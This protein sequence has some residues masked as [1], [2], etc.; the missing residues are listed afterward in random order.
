MTLPLK[1]KYNSIITY[2]YEGIYRQLLVSVCDNLQV[3]IEGVKSRSRKRP[4]VEAR[5]V[6]IKLA[7]EFHPY[8]LSL[9]G[10]MINRSHTSVIRD[11]KVVDDV[12]EVYRKYQRVKEAL[13]T[14]GRSSR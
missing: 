8:N 10:H 13:F 4:L 2:A 1:P 7:Q 9:M 12:R 11:I 14:A 5:M 3:P 6:Y